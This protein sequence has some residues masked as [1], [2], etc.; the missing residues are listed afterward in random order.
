MNL[1]SKK[2]LAAKILKIGAGRIWIDPDRAED[3]EIAITREEIRRLIHERAIQAEPK[4]GIS[5]SRVRI[6]AV[7]KRKGRRR[8]EGRKKGKKTSKI[9]SKKRWMIKVRSQRKKFNTI[10][11][12]IILTKYAFYHVLI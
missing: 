4:Q 12:S 2:K 6:L 11:E 8:G 1:K 9:S 10:K 5:R 3:V 7:K